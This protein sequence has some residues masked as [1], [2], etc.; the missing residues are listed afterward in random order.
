[1]DRVVRAKSGAR[2]PVVLSREGVH[3]VLDRA[4]GTPKLMARLP[5]RARLRLLGCCRLRIEDLDFW[6][7]E[8]LLRACRG[9]RDR[10]TLLSASFREALRRQVEAVRRPYLADL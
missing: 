2:L 9:D 6:D 3:A 7:G 10:R 4:R 8:I 5:Y 1:V